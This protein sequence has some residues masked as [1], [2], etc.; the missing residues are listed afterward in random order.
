MKDTIL[1]VNGLEIKKGAKYKITHKVDKSAPTGLQK[2]GTT[3]SPTEKISDYFK[4][5]YFIK[6]KST[7]EGIYDTGFY[8]DSPCYF[9]NTREEAQNLVRDTN[10]YIVKPYE[11]KYGVGVLSHL[12]QD[13]WSNQVMELRSGRVFDTN[14]IEDLFDLYFAMLGFWLT[15]INMIGDARFINSHFC[16]EDL[17]EVRDSKIK[18]MEYSL[19]AF[20]KLNELSNSNEDDFKKFVCF[21][22]E[23][24]SYAQR[25]KA[26]L[27]KEMYDFIQRDNYSAI[28]FNETY[29]IFKENKDYILVY[30]KLAELLRKGVVRVSGGKY[31]YNEV[32]LG[33][34]LKGA[35]KAVANNIDFVDIKT[36][37]F[38][39]K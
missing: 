32:E 37:I 5:S 22:T 21:I 38:D 30:Y 10:T 28:K 36:E 23:N 17:E 2:E 1:T 12:N 20:N 26:S 15:P 33:L 39:L 18:Q 7:G 13:F 35:S 14:N 3:K 25:D 29:Q 19:K 11:S 9:G 27:T 31:Y 6:N 4:C 16:I 24:I 8:T 34:E